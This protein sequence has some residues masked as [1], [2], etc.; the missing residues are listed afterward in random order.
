MES[1]LT[2]C[3]ICNNTHGNVKYLAREM[4]YGYRDQF[5]Y[6][7]CS[8]CG[9]LQ[10]VEVP[11]DLGKYY[12]EN[13][14]SFSKRSVKK[15][16]LISLY[17]KRQ[18]TKYSLY[19]TGILGKYL[20]KI[21]GH[22]NLPMWL[23]NAK[24]A[25]DNEILDVGSGSGDLLLGLRDRGFSRLTGIDPLIKKDIFYRNGVQ[26]YKRNLREMTQLF[27]LI[28]LHH[29]F[30]HVPDPLSML[31]DIY[32][33]IKPAGLVLIRI[34]LVSSFAW[35]TYKTNWVQLDAPRHLF[36]HSVRSMELLT[37]KC[38][39]MIENIDYDSKGFQLWG[40]EQCIK[41]IHLHDQRSYN[42]NP[43]RSIF[44][45]ND[46]RAFEEKAEELNNSKDGD[47]ACFYL[48]KI[49]RSV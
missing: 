22:P 3:K 2:N 39:F 14:F 4:M 23:K 31:M 5:E 7:E 6:L 36:L 46:M 48:R 43:R 8:K 33:K 49:N 47:Q 32:Q 21:G 41:N 20:I 44:S 16:N 18:R 1:N 24:P 40:S 34:P 10:I 26:I 27:D 42:I 25:F 9:C 28:M 38:G 11:S 15:L 30:E 29:S 12:P 45:Y 35:R 37:S 17:I 19:S 13:Y